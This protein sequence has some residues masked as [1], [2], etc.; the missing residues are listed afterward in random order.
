MFFFLKSW[1]QSIVLLVNRYEV[2]CHKLLQIVV[3]RNVWSATYVT[4]FAFSLFFFF[5]KNFCVCLCNLQCINQKPI[6]FMFQS[7]SLSFL[8]LQNI[9]LIVYWNKGSELY[10]SFLSWETK[11]LGYTI[12]YTLYYRYI[13]IG[14][15]LVLFFLWVYGL[16]PLST[17]WFLMHTLW[18]WKK[19]KGFHWVFSFLHF[20]VFDFSLH[21]EKYHMLFFFS[22][23]W[24]QLCCCVVDFW[25]FLAINFFVAADGF[26]SSI[27]FKK[28]YYKL[29][30]FNW[31]QVNDDVVSK[32]RMDFQHLPFI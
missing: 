25:F 24:K 13:Y 23:I 30:I 31:K 16:L 14:F 18:N 19:N 9:S 15:S 7:W 1:S 22:A 29:D 3:I 10:L 8:M 6:F 17:D 28:K 32:Y 11:I 5:K 12:F 26:C 2:Y 27:F 4:F 20:S 21:F